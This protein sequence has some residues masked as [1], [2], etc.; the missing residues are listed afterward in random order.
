MQPIDE[1]NCFEIN[2]ELQDEANE[3]VDVLL[4]Q[5]KLLKN[6]IKMREETITSLCKRYKID[7]VLDC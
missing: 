6:E 5:I 1:I 3:Q 7:A 4:D 2:E